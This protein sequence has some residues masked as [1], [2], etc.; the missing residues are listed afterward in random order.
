MDI[1]TELVTFIF[2]NIQFANLDSLS[3]IWIF[4]TKIFQNVQSSFR[5][6]NAMYTQEILFTCKIQKFV[7]STRF[8]AE[9]E[10][11]HDKKLRELQRS[12]MGFVVLFYRIKARRQKLEF[13]KPFLCV[14]QW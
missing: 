13:F 8:C 7:I 10:K 14:V 5:R 2:R 3:L 9:N 6:E 4:Q 11:P 12:P 1:C